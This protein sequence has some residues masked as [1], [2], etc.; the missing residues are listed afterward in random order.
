LHPGWGVN[1]EK[2]KRYVANSIALS[3]WCFAGSVFQKTYFQ[4]DDKNG[5]GAALAS[6]IKARLFLQIVCGTIFGRNMLNG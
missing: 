1:E 6:S 4:H 2:I 5:D 3:C